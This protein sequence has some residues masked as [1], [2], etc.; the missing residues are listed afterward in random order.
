MIAERPEF[1]NQLR[2]QQLLRPFNTF[3]RF[4]KSVLMDSVSSNDGPRSSIIVRKRAIT[5]NKS[6]ISCRARK[7][8]CDATVVGIP[9]SVCIGREIAE[10]CRLPTRKDRT[11]SVRRLSQFTSTRAPRGACADLFDLAGR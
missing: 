6:C 10:T 1:I 7:V 3:A 4:E 11:R 2:Y 5:V 9:C 8:K